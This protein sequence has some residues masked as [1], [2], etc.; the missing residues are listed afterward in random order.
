[1]SISLKNVILGKNIKDKTR[2]SSVYNT[3]HRQLNLLQSGLFRNTKK[4]IGF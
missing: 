4:K 1:M 2:I 3:R